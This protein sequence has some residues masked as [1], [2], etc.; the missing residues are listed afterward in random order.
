MAANSFQETGLKC[1]R[2]QTG[3]NSG[4]LFTRYV[5]RSGGMGNGCLY[6]SGTADNP[7]LFGGGFRFYPEPG[8]PKFC[9]RRT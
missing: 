3:G 5:N 1:I 2:E 8:R 6:E 9:G 4:T 7:S